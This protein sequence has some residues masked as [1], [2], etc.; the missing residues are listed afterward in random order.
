MAYASLDEVVVRASPEVR[1]GGGLDAATGREVRER[2][3][4][5]Q[6]KTSKLALWGPNETNLLAYALTEKSVAAASALLQMGNLSSPGATADW[7]ILDRAKGEMVQAH[8]TF[9][10]RAGEIIRDPRQPVS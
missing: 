2:A 5:L 8:A 3:L 10:Q 4:E 7:S 9:L 6:A 1:S